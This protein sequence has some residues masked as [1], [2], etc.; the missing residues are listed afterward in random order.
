MTCTW[1]MLSPS[2]SCSFSTLSCALWWLLLTRSAAFFLCLPVSLICWLRRYVAKPTV[3]VGE[4]INAIRNQGSDAAKKSRRSFQRQYTKNEIEMARSRPEAPAPIRP[5]PATPPNTMEKRHRIVEAAAHT[6][7]PSAAEP[8]SL[9]DS[10]A[11][12]RR[13][14]MELVK[15]MRTNASHV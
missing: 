1:K 8:S 2:A 7:T 4:L 9:S 12:R 13:E 3:T 6:G 15:W 5:P 10:P 11:Q 14:V